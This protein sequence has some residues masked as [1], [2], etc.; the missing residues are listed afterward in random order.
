MHLPSLLPVLLASSVCAWQRPNQT[1]SDEA[2]SLIGITTVAPGQFERFTYIMDETLSWIQRN[3][4]GTL[5][6][7]VYTLASRAN[8]TEISFF[9]KSAPI[10]ANRAARDTHSNSQHYAEFIKSLT[11]LL[12][13]E[14]ILLL[15]DYEQGFS[16]AGGKGV[17]VGLEW[18]YEE[19]EATATTTSETSIDNK[20][21]V[22]QHPATAVPKSYKSLKS[23][24]F[25]KSNK[26][27]FRPHSATA[28]SAFLTNTVPEIFAT[29]ADCSTANVALA[30]FFLRS[31]IA[32]R[33]LQTVTGVF[34]ELPLFY[35]KT[36]GTQSS[37]QHITL[38]CASAAYGIR[39]NLPAALA[40]GRSA[41]DA[42]I[43]Q[44]SGDL[45]TFSDRSAPGAAILNVVLCNFY[46]ACIPQRATRPASTSSFMMCL[47]DNRR[48]RNIHEKGLVGLIRSCGAVSFSPDSADGRLFE[49]ARHYIA[50][51]CLESGIS[52]SEALGQAVPTLDRDDDD[53]CR[54]LTSCVIRAADAAAATSKLDSHFTREELLDGLQRIQT[55]EQD[56]E[57]WTKCVP[58]HWNF[59]KHCNFSWPAQYACENRCDAYY[60]IQV[61]SNWNCYR[62]ARLILLER[63]IGLIDIL[64][65]LDRED[66]TAMRHASLKAIAQIS[67]DVCASL[68]FH[69]GTRD[70]TSEHISFPVSPDNEGD[71][72]RNQTAGIHGWFL[73]VLPICRLMKTTHIPIAH[74]AW[75]TA[76]HRRICAIV[77]HKHGISEDSTS[78]ILETA[79]PAF[80]SALPINSSHIE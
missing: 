26:P 33:R 53:F 11:P 64:S 67:E 55:V 25:S 58:E 14:P 35:F 74:T 15:G 47:K 65:I 16:L 54:L 61:A 27:L 44:L 19:R 78:E 59:T 62:R 73:I 34:E 13:G 32:P 6:L 76:Q 63:T 22:T 1:A 69:L 42:A 71:A 37:L 18:Y 50:N 77:G 24:I 51:D 3:E 23:C 17:A 20:P 45:A 21:S 5:Q 56:L 39:H 72:V 31:I 9:E 4:P 29:D 30:A 52:A 75:I 28:M 12:V 40:I 79:V 38:A 49:A 2:T 68:P 48:F 36:T 66:R 70:P 43:A 46:E 10:Y 80:A 8:G 7:E 60:D 57:R 41:Y